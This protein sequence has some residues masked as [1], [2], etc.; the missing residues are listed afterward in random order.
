MPTSPY[1]T[2]LGMSDGETLFTPNGMH[3]AK[4]KSTPSYWRNVFYKAFNKYS[5]IYAS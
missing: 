2:G 3:M 5:K 4:K 1:L